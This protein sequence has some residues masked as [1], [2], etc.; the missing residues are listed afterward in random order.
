MRLIICL[1]TLRFTL[2]LAPAAAPAAEDLIPSRALTNAA[3]LVEGPN[4]GNI[5]RVTTSIFE[6]A[7]YLKQPFN[8]EYSSKF[9]D[10]YLDSL[11]S[12]HLYFLQSDLKEF[13]KYRT[14]LDDLTKEG[15]TSPARVI[16]SRF[17]ERLDQQYHYVLALLKTE[18]FDF[19]SNERFVFNR[20]T[21][22]RPADMTE[23]KQ[24]WHERVRYEYL[25][26]K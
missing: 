21:L 15:D 4:D 14:T 25:Q 1:L 20:K 17:R 8:D 3:P 18:K 11:D 9:L 2:A 26:E 19:T 5:A 7:H 24:L 22:P 6:S 12:L 16:F 10:R 23:A 13:E